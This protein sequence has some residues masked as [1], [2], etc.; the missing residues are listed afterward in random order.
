M[1]FF[2]SISLLINLKTQHG[3][4]ATGTLGVDFSLLE[5]AC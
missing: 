4:E 5:C 2:D 3:A 1:I